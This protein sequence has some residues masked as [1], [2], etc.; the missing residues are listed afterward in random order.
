MQSQLHPL[1]A[2]YLTCFSPRLMPSH[3]LPSLC[4]QNQFFISCADGKTVHNGIGDAIVNRIL[5]AHRSGFSVVARLM[6]LII[7]FFYTHS[8]TLK[9]Q[10]THS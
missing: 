9:Q 3:H 10:S 2:T 6:W 4:P 8:L 1:P 7:Y 5:R